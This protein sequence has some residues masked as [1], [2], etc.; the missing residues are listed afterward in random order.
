MSSSGDY[1]IESQRV[2]DIETEMPPLLVVVGEA[3]PLHRSLETLS[4]HRGSSSC[5]RCMRCQR[6]RV[7]RRSHL[8]LL[9]GRQIDQSQIDRQP[10]VV[11]RPTGDVTLSKQV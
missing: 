2:R 8:E 1:A 3:A 5:V 9:A 7:E 4:I 10:E 6:E 11:P